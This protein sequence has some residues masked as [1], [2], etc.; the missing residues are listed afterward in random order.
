MLDLWPGHPLPSEFPFPHILYDLS[1][2]HHR[3]RPLGTLQNP[4]QAAQA[5]PQLALILF[6]WEEPEDG[7]MS[8]QLVF[9]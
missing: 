5:N 2:H 1:L 6:L 3:E 9:H 7:E 4:T 8:S